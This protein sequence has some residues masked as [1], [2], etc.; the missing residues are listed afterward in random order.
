[1]YRLGGVSSEHEMTWRQYA[2]AVLAFSFTSLLAVYA[3]ERL[4]GLLPLNPSRCLPSLP[5]P[6]LTPP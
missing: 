6:L 5:T 2:G 4:Q 1:M 3:V